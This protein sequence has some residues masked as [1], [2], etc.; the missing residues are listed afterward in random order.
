MIKKQESAILR[1][2]RLFSAVAVWG[3]IAA[4]VSVLIGWWL[5]IPALTRLLPGLVT[6]KPNTALCF[7][8]GSISLWL[9][10]NPASDSITLNGYRRFIARA[11]AVV[12]ALI[13]IL[14]FLER[15]SGKDLGVDLLL[16]RGTLLATPVPHPGLM[17][18]ASGIAFLLLGCALLSLDWEPKNGSHPAQ[19]LAFGA[20]V[21]GF[22]ALLG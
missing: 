1:H 22:V 11:C 16:F 2:C 7:I 20:V 6:M 19:V 4:G 18:A 17:A 5:D 14:S 15:I 3:S 12:V 10:R 21:I 13:G 9:L 8:L